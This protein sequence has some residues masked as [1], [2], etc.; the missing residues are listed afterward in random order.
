MSF[1]YYYGHLGGEAPP[2]P[3]ALYIS[4]NAATATDSAG[5]ASRDAVAA[6]WCE[7][8]GSKIGWLSKQEF[9]TYTR[10]GSDWGGG[11]GFDPADYEVKADW[12]GDTL[13]TGSSATG[14][15][16]NGA[17]AYKWRL[18]VL[19]TQS[20]AKSG[21]LTLTIRDVATQTQQAQA[22]FV[23]EAERNT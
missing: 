18:R 8:V 6:W 12:T 22:N 7:G 2:A 11:V 21:T 10:N 5:T 23:I 3:P 19:S 17:A 20:A 13:D 16:L 15:W 14:I 4:L 1:Q 9:L